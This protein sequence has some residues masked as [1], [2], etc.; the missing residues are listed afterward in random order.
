MS[1]ED[2]GKIKEFMRNVEKSSI[3]NILEELK[4]K[5]VLMYS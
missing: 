4:A 5:I 3:Q 1:E 2:I